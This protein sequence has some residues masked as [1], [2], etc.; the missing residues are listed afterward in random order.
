MFGSRS[1]HRSLQAGQSRS[2][3]HANQY[4]VVVLVTPTI[5]LAHRHSVMNPEMDIGIFITTVA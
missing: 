1:L 2:Q 5:L 3:V 4:F